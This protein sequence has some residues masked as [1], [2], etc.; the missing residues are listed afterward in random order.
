MNQEAAALG[1][2]LAAERPAALDDVHAKSLNNLG[3]RLKL[4][5]HK[6]ALVAIQ[7]AGR[8]A[9]ALI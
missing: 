1:R 9:R 3:C 5:R 2:A 6:E 4:S 7:E 8:L